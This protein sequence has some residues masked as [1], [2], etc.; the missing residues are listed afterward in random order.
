MKDI[1]RD[2]KSIDN[3]ITRE[4]VS[5]RTVCKIWTRLPVV[6]HYYSLH[7][8]RHRKAVFG[9]CQLLLRIR[10][11]LWLS[12][13]D[14]YRIEIMF[15]FCSIIYFKHIKAPYGQGRRMCD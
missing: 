9:F 4:Y 12:H 7:A 2:V 13:M 15:Y 10:H 11:I 14:A 3:D 6:L 1:L 5:L 8:H